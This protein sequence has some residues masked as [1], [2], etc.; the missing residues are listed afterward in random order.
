MGS[1]PSEISL[2]HDADSDF[3]HSQSTVFSPGTP[4]RPPQ[5][6]SSQESD[7]LSVEEDEFEGMGG[8][9]VVWDA[10][11]RDDAM[12]FEA[13]PN[14]FNSEVLLTAD[15]SPLQILQEFISQDMVEV[16][17]EESNRYASQK[18]IRN[19]AALTPHEFWRFIATSLAMGIV[20]KST[21]EEYWAVKTQFATPFFNSVMPRDRYR[22]LLRSLH[23]MDNTA[24]PANNK[25]KFVKLGSFMEKLFENV[26]KVVKM[27]EYLCLDESFVPFKGRLSIKQ[28]NPKKRARFGVKLF[29]LADCATKLIV[30][31]LPYQ[32]ANTKMKYGH[33]KKEL[34]FGG[35][36]V[37]SMLEP[38]FDKGHRVV[39][40]NYFN[41]PKLARYLI[42]K[43]TYVLGTVQK[44]RKGMPKN[45]RMLR[46]MK[47]GEVEVFSDGSILVERWCD[48]RDVNML[49]TFMEHSMVNVES[50]NPNNTREKP[51]TVVLYNSKMG[52]VDDAD[53][54]IAPV[55]SI[56]KTYKW[57]RKV[58]FHL[59]DLAC[60][61]AFLMKK[62][63][64]GINTKYRL[65]LEEVI[66]NILT[67]YPQANRVP[68]GRPPQQRDDQRLNGP[69]FPHKVLKANGKS[70]KADCFYC[71]N[72]CNKKRTSTVYGCRQCQKRLCIG[73]GV[74]CFER[75]HTQST[76]RRHRGQQQQSQLFESPSDNESDSAEL[77]ESLLA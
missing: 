10:D 7:D 60:Y 61:N 30:D 21:I 51:G 11:F 45:R 70:S 39:V 28:Y 35:A 71:Y 33:L 20:K 2:A 77:S 42:S 47:K 25:D 62:H 69:H 48:R 36:A 4:V 22:Q 31:I 56:R 26:R 18:N 44:R 74:S 34:G 14:A 1:V 5:V 64:T 76:L 23:F 6:S 3:E 37:L 40:D 24:V 13:D 38:Y 29:K 66:N 54:V 19:Y 16:I 65:F 49:N 72:V 12:D 15:S 55:A 46:K 50:S 27:G 52:A 43:K 17:C 57:Y 53:K 68:R 9:Q 73:A 8:S 63:L 67:E 59:I 58:A 41:S 75:F 32:G